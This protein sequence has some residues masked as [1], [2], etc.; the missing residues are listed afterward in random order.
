MF[1]WKEP[2]NNLSAESVKMAHSLITTSLD[3]MESLFKAH[4]SRL[5]SFCEDQAQTACCFAGAKDSKEAFTQLNAL[6][7]QALEGA[8]SHWQE[9]CTIVAKTQGKMTEIMQNNL[10][11]A[12]ETCSANFEA[13]SK[14]V[15]GNNI[16][17][18]ALKSSF[19]ATAAMMDTITRATQ[20]AAE[21][22]STTAKATE[23]AKNTSAKRN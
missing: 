13:L 23:A 14:S 21:F 10:S 5:R 9:L 4:M 2:I 7:T 20:Q 6:N 11:K 22:A 8:M 16:A 17:L 15:P 1:T 12:R 19:G 18:D 3:G